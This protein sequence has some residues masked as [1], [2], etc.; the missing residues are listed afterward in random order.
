MLHNRDAGF[1]LRSSTIAF[2]AF[3]FALLALIASALDGTVRASLALERLPNLTPV[4][5]PEQTLLSQ[6]ELSDFALFTEARYLRHPSQADLHSAFQDHPLSFD[7][8]PGGS[9]IL[10]YRPGVQKGPQP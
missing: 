10:P 1:R 5:T 2:T 4:Q 3:A 8:F 7:H 9:L 6:L